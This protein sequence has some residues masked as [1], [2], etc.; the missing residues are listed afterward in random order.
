MDI[1]LDCRI[2]IEEEYSREEEL[3]V[4]QGLLDGDDGGGQHG[5]LDPFHHH[6]HH[7]D[8]L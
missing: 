7:D 3:G 8:D 2:S 6:R 1:K 4:L 5:E